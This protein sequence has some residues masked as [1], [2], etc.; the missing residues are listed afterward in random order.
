MF[1]TS[2]KL[3]YCIGV[4]S[5]REL[6]SELSESFESTNSFARSYSFTGLRSMPFTSLETLITYV[7][8]T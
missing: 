7:L 1:V 2:S 4:C 3:D 8:L 6:S 5:I